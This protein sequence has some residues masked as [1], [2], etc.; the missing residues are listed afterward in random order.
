MV[1]QTLDIE[2][3]TYLKHFFYSWNLEPGRTMS[4][5][6]WQIKTNSI[7]VY[8]SSKHLH[9]IVIFAVI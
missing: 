8:C 2:P 6:M 4:V 1:T 5:N 9:Y 3:P 7:P